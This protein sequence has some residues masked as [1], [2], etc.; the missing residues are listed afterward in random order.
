VPSAA[1]HHT[2]FAI[3]CLDVSRKNSSLV[4]SD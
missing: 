3:D 4:F 2:P 1:S